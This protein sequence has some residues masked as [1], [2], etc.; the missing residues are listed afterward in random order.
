[1]N[2][3]IL[4]GFM[5]SGKTTIGKKISKILN[6]DI[7]DMDDEIE[8]ECNMH[9]SEI[10]KLYGEKYFRKKELVLLNKLLKT[11]NIIIST[12]GGIIENEEVVDILKN[13]RYVIWLDASEETI[14]NRIESELDNR[15][16]LNNEKNLKLTIKK[17]MND[18]YKKYK[19]VSSLIVDVNGKNIDEVASEIL[20]YIDKN[21]LL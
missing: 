5:G 17:I 10:F 18:R 7:I 11:D 2:N 19:E 3:I 16:K 4:I 1:M 21:V 13:Q 15:P 9:I 20:V 12:G 14:I 6:L 8:K